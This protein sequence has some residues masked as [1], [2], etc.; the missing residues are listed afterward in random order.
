VKEKRPD[1]YEVVQE[2]KQASQERKCSAKVSASP[3]KSCPDV[4]E[5][6]FIFMKE[7]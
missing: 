1:V 7:T 4:E 2:A 5:L 6:E 3:K